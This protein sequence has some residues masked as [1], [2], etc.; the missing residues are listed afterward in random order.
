MK[1]LM[2]ILLFI[3]I[4][5]GC[6]DLRV[7]VDYDGSSRTELIQPYIDTY[8]AGSLFRS[9]VI[10][11]DGKIGYYETY[12]FWNND[13]LFITHFI[14]IINETDPSVPDWYIYNEGIYEAGIY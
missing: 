13:G 6:E 11:F 9:W 4:L 14:T 2:L 12:L 8:D 3:T 1:A 5:F 7:P 10:I